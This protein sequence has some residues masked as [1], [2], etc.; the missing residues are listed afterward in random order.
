IASTKPEKYRIEKFNIHRTIDAVHLLF[1]LEVT[2][3]QGI[4]GITQVIELRY[5]KSIST[6]FH[7]PKCAPPR[8]TARAYAKVDIRGQ[9]FRIFGNQISIQVQFVRALQP[10]VTV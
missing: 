4:R 1:F 2:T 5:Y 6:L 8:R 9:L 3:L 10:E 7:P